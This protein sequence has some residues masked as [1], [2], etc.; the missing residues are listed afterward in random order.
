MPDARA[1][2]NAG[3]SFGGCRTYLAARRFRNS[4]TFSSVRSPK[5]CFAAVDRASNVCSLWASSLTLR[6]RCPN[7]RRFSAAL[8]RPSSPNSGN[9]TEYLSPFGACTKSATSSC[10]RSSRCSSQPCTAVANF[11]GSLARDGRPSG[12]MFA[13]IERPC[14]NWTVMIAGSSGGAWVLRTPFSCRLPLYS[15]LRCSILPFCTKYSIASANVDLPDP[16][17]P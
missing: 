6:T 7:W 13:R 14:S 17:A 3:R 5:C 1:F 2:V 8:S 4:A 15:C 10:R 9:K 16:F 12:L 11:A